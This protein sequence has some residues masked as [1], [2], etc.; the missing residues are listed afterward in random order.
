MMITEF[1]LSAGAPCHNRLQPGEYY[2]HRSP[3]RVG[4]SVVRGTSGTQQ[5]PF[6]SSSMEVIRYVEW[7]GTVSHILPECQPRLWS[8]SQAHAVPR[9]VSFPSAGAWPSPRGAAHLYKVG[10]TSPARDF[11]RDEKAETR[12]ASMRE[13]EFTEAFLA[14]GPLGRAASAGWFV[15]EDPVC[16][17]SFKVMVNMPQLRP[18]LLLLAKR[19]LMGPQNT[20]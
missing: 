20:S 13:S 11:H 17:D 3:V 10:C 6:S 4:V 2:E 15:I 18:G 9:P 12:D 1:S 14:G 19:A 5:S 16:Q 8:T 7:G